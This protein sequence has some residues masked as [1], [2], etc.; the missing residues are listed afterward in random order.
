MLVNLLASTSLALF[1]AVR[2][3]AL[4]RRDQPLP[5]RGLHLSEWLRRQLSRLR[6]SA[7][8]SAFAALHALAR[9]TEVAAAEATAAVAAAGTPR[10]A[11]AVATA[12]GAA[13][14][15]PESPHRGPASLRRPSLIEG[16]A[17]VSCWH[18]LAAAVHARVFAS[19]FCRRR[20]T[21]H[22]AAADQA[23]GNGMACLHPALH[24]PCLQTR[25][26]QG[27]TPC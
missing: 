6:G 7:S 5:Q 21:S 1:L 14:R 24:P 13:Q 3:L 19:S 4:P 18:C 23:C 2:R 9:E 20:H 25:P 12:A 11:P 27:W 15:Q 17:H 16:T 26:L 8:M 10:A 22:S